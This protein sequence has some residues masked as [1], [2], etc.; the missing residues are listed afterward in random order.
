MAVAMALRRALRLPQTWAI[1]GAPYTHGQKHPLQGS[2]AAPLARGRQDDAAVRGVTARWRAES[3][4]ITSALRDLLSSLERENV[5][6]R[7]SRALAETAASKPAAARAAGSSHDPAGSEPSAKP[8]SSSVLRLSPER[9]G[10]LFT[11]LQR[12]DRA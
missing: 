11:H 9:M 2:R 5:A 1:P 7:A 4:P 12:C 3:R 6:E 10:Q 8:W